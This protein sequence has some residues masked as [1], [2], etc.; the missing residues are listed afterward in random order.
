M[1]ETTVQKLEK[2]I[3]DLRERIETLGQDGFDWS[4]W[5]GLWFL[6][7]VVFLLVTLVLAVAALVSVGVSLVGS[8]IALL[9]ALLS[10]VIG[11]IMENKQ[12]SL[13]LD[14]EK[15]RTEIAKLRTLI[16]KSK[17]ADLLHEDK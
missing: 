13:Y 16:E 15:L 11:L 1:T 6:I 5:A 17:I 12:K 10:L 8:L 4:S 7:G 9:I 14:A 3:E 2:E